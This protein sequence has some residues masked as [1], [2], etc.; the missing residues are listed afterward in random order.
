MVAQFL[1]NVLLAVGLAVP[2]AHDWIP[3]ADVDG[4]RISI[5]GNSLLM[6]KTDAGPVIW[7]LVR[8]DMA[9]PVPVQGKKKVGKYFINNVRAICAADKLVIEKSTL[10]AADGESLATGEDVG[11]MVNKHK[12]LTFTTE[13]LKLMCNAGH[14]TEPAISV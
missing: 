2:V 8:L 13:Y 10:Y 3:F 11:E 6:K 1:A 4:A 9:Q 14:N 7:G 12:P 5:D